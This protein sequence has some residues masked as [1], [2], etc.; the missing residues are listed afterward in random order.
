MESTPNFD[1]MRQ[2]F[3]WVAIQ[4]DVFCPLPDRL[5]K[6]LKQ[7]EASETSDLSY[8][9]NDA[10]CPFCNDTIDLARSADDRLLMDASPAALLHALEHDFT[11]SNDGAIESPPK[12][13]PVPAKT[14]EAMAVR[15][16]IDAIVPELGPQIVAKLKPLLHQAMVSAE[17]V[18]HAIFLE[19][20]ERIDRTAFRP[21]TSWLIY[22]RWLARNR[23]IDALTSQAAASLEQIREEALGRDDPPDRQVQRREKRSRQHSV[24]DETLRGF[25]RAHE[26]RP[27]GRR[28]KEV[29]ERTLRGQSPSQVADTMTIPVNQVYVDTTRGFQWIARRIKDDDIRGS[30]FGNTDGGF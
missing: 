13:V 30:L 19:T 22:L 16:E 20:V 7:P 29:V 24:I 25:C 28:K 17:D 5:A 27:S 14:P 6:H 21:K 12:A 23:A 1:R 2:L 26:T 8:H 10:Q 4:T 18:W 15:E 11:G 9:V 3:Y